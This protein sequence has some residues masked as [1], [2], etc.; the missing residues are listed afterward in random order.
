MRTRCSLINKPTTIASLI[1]LA[2]Y[3]PSMCRCVPGAAFL[4]CQPGFY[5]AQLQF[6]P[7]SRC[8]CHREVSLFASAKRVAIHLCRLAIQHGLP[9]LPVYSFGE[10]QLF[11][12]LVL[13]TDV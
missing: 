1:D 12:T 2:K 9:L 7:L 5:Q 4:P 13:F 11:R 3:Q 6:M 10:N 8:M